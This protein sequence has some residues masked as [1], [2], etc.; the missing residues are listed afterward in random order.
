MTRETV[1]RQAGKL[2]EALKEG[3]PARLVRDELMALE[4][5]EDALTAEIAALETEAPKPLI[6]PNL[7][8]VYRQ[9]VAALA[10][11]LD[12]PEL[13]PEAMD[14]IRSLVEKVVLVPDG[15]GLAIELHGALAGILALGADGRKPASGE[16]G[17]LQTVLVAGAGFEPATF[18]L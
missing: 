5:R 3:T 4:A 2:V 11:A 12:H 9:K 16:A 6:H 8:E 1:Q 18:R 17:F 13:G 15:D 10:D 7:A 14:L